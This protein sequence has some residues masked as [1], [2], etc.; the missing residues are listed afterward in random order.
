MVTPT[1]PTSD[2]T[3]TPPNHIKLSKRELYPLPFEV[4]YRRKVDYDCNDLV[5]YYLLECCTYTNDVAFKLDGNIARGMS[6]YSWQRASYRG[7]LRTWYHNVDKAV[8]VAVKQLLTQI[9]RTPAT[10]KALLWEI[11]TKIKPKADTIQTDYYMFKQLYPRLTNH[12]STI[13]V[14]KA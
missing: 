7:T 6:T 4:G 5:A 9:Y 13:V 3:L 11:G 1:S 12:I 8:D 14:D 2:T 10:Y